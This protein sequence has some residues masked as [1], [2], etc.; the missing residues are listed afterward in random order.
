MRKK[1]FEMAQ[2]YFMRSASTGN[3]KRRK[4]HFFSD[5]DYHGV[6]AAP[7]F[8]YLLRVDGVLPSELAARGVR[9]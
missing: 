5:A 1:P 9:A 7:F 2:K 3:T 8:R 4:L 6:E